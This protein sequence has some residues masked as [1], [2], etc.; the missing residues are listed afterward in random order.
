[1]AADV[2]E[3]PLEHV[4]VQFAHCYKQQAGWETVLARF[5]RGNGVLLDLEFLTDSS[6]R[7]VAVRYMSSFSFSAWILSLKSCR[8][9]DITLGLLGTSTSYRLSAV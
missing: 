5:V 8:H 6:G 2:S 9:L 1:M 4:H 3:V 7:R